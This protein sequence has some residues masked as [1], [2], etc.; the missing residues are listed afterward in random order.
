MDFVP[1]HEFR[2][3]VKRHK[4]EHRVRRSSCWDQ[5]LSIGFAQLT[6]RESLRD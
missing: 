4:G 5:F 3:I 2:Q 6:Y 1:R